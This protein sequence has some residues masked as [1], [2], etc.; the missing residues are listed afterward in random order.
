MAVAFDRAPNAVIAAM[1]ER[2]DQN[3]QALLDDPH[4]LEMR[5]STLRTMRLSNTIT[6]AFGL[7]AFFAILFMMLG[8]HI[9]DTP[10]ALVLMIII[11]IQP[12]IGAMMAHNE[13]RMLI[14]FR[15]LR[16]D[17]SV[18]TP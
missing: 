16:D 7:V 10:P 3:F 11:F 8:K 2:S 17:R 15:K 6:A 9:K 4:K 5:V 12:A 1:F 13:L 14:L 18:V